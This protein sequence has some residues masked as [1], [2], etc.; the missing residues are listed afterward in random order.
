MGRR[1]RDSREASFGFL[2][3]GAPQPVSQPFIALVQSTGHRKNATGMSARTR[4]GSLT[5]ARANK[6]RSIASP[7]EIPTA[8]ARRRTLTH[9]LISTQAHGRRSHNL[10]GPRPAAPARRHADPRADLRRRRHDQDGAR[11]H[12]GARRH[13]AHHALPRPVGAARARARR[14]RGGTSWIS[15][16]HVIETF[17]ITTPYASSPA[18]PRPTRGRRRGARP[19]RRAR[20]YH[21][22]RR[23][24]PY[25]H[26]QARRRGP[27]RPVVALWDR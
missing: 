22:I 9:W 16:S 5:I 6:S 4:G 12:D 19:T 27:A 8:S 20:P 1:M 3:S 17:R 11:A 26:H 2:S 18:A 10:H 14:R 13:R 24:R 15:D 7:G 21:L 23:P 25:R